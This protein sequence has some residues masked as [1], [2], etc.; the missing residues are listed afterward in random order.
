MTVEDRELP[1]HGAGDVAV[2]FVM[3]GLFEVLESDTRWS[4]HA[5]PTHELLWTEHGS[6]TAT[7]GTRVFTITPSVGLWIPAGVRHAGWTA[8]G[9]E[10]RAMQFGVDSVPAIAEQP[11]PVDVTPLLRLLL[12]RLNEPDLGDEA[13]AHAETVVLDLLEPAPNA[14]LLRLPESP[15]LAPIVSAVRHDPAD[16]TT[17]AEWAGRLGVS[18][19]TLSR[20]FHAETGLG[21][22]R[23]LAAIRAQVAIGMLAHG[24][25]L[26]EVATAAGFGSASAFGTAFRRVTGVSPGRF[27]AQ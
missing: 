19:R 23:W 1:V 10:L 25:D 16:P 20:A 12:E 14:L 22:S 15:L 13:R 2:P 26:D 21:F 8:A 27:R 7:V 9:V 6:C 18:S 5:H 17:L 3:A 24:A 11:V 4:E